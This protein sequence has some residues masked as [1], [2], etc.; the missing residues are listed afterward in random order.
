VE[1]PAK[2]WGGHQLRMLKFVKVFVKVRLRMLKFV[3]VR[4]RML[5]FVKVFITPSDS[6]V[7][8][9][10]NRRIVITL[11]VLLEFKLSPTGVLAIWKWWIEL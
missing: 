11:S 6:F 2:R 7:I 9:G 4:L 8:V 5:K 10:Y 1:G 3:K